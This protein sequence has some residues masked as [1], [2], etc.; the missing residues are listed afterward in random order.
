MTTK[1]KA[2]FTTMYVTL[3]DIWYQLIYLYKINI[4]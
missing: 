2:L 1:L 3:V 4:H